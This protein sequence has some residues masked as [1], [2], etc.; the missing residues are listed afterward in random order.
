MKSLTW[1]LVLACFY[2][3]QPISKV[4]SNC[5]KLELVTIRQIVQFIDFESGLTYKQIGDL[6]GCHWET[7]R[8][9]VRQIKRFIEPINDKIP[10]KKMKKDIEFLNRDYFKELI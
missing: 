8:S 7:V 2:F 1:H 5:R 6:Y 9:N 10:D 3:G 4:M